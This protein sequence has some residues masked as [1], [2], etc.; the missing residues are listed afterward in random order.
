MDEGDGD[1]ETETLTE[2]TPEE[3]V[4]SE[5]D[6]NFVP[7]HNRKPTTNTP[8]MKRLLMSTKATSTSESNNSDSSIQSYTSGQVPITL[9]VHLNKSK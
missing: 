1:I 7:R 9:V 8:S 2:T 3:T 4:A 6:M 5:H